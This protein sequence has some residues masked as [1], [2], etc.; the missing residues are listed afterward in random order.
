M[1]YLTKSLGKHFLCKILLQA[2]VAHFYFCTRNHEL[3]EKLWAQANFVMCLLLLCSGLS[4]VCPPQGAV[5]GCASP[6]DALQL[7]WSFFCVTSP[8][9][10]QFC[11]NHYDFFPFMHGRESAL[12]LH[13]RLFLWLRLTDT[14][15]NAH[16][17][18]G[19]NNIFLESFL[20]S[21]D[22]KT[23]H[24]FCQTASSWRLSYLQF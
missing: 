10:S 14:H 23:C 4:C 13:H 2:W 8:Q 7:Y 1:K 18:R 24:Y 20:N 15:R 12:V 11:V 21:A 6:G 19:R 3:L 22:G 9:A 16:A 5:G 17:V